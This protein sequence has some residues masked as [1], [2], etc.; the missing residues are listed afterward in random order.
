MGL[1]DANT[2]DLRITSLQCVKWNVGVMTHTPTNLGV[3][4]APVGL[5]PKKRHI[6][7][8]CADDWL[9][10][11]HWNYKGMDCNARHLLLQLKRLN[12]M[13]SVNRQNVS[14]T[15]RAYRGSANSK[16]LF[17][18]MPTNLCLQTHDSYRH[19]CRGV[20]RECITEDSGCP[21]VTTRIH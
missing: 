20:H 15:S 14:Q 1:P 2:P 11:L 4:L 19:S 9:H 21:Q 16:Q 6:L 5:L 18:L 8:N 10:W 12:S 7:G 3:N 13:P 17:I